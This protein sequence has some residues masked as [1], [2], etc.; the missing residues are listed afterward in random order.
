MQRWIAG[1][2]VL[3]I[4]LLCSGARRTAAQ[5]SNTLQIYWRHEAPARIIHTFESDIDQDGFGEIGLVTVDDTIELLRNDRTPLWSSAHQT[6][7]GVLAITARADS[8]VYATSQQLVQVDVNGEIDWSEGISDLPTVKDLY[9]VIDVFGRSSLLVLF[10]DGSMQLYNR[11]GSLRWHYEHPEDAISITDEIVLVGDVDADGLDDVLF[12]YPTTPNSSLIQ[13]IDSQDG[14]VKWDATI[15]GRV[16]AFSPVRFTNGTSAIAVGNDRGNIVMINGAEEGIW[17]P[18]SLEQP[19]T[20]LTMAEWPQADRI[21]VAATSDGQIVGLGAT[22]RRIFESRICE[23]NGLFVT[24]TQCDTPFTSRIQRLEVGTGDEAQGVALVALLEREGESSAEI[25]FFNRSL[26]LLQNY[27]ISPIKTQPLLV[28]T[29]RD[30]RNEFLLTAFGSV[31][32]ISPSTSRRSPVQVNATLPSPPSAL[33]VGDFNQDRIDEMIVGDVSGRLSK[34]GDALYGDWETLNAD[35]IEPE[36][37]GVAVAK[38]ALLKTPETGFSAES[39]HFLTVYNRLIEQG[40]GEPP[41]RNSTLALRR[42]LDGGLVWEEPISISGHTVTLLVDQAQPDLANVL[43]GLDNGVLAKFELVYQDDATFGARNSWVQ[44]DNNWTLSL[45]SEITYGALLERD[46]EMGSRFVITTRNTVQRYDAEGTRLYFI[47]INNAT[48]LCESPAEL[49]YLLDYGGDVSQPCLLNRR[50]GL[51]EQLLG[52]STRPTAHTSDTFTYQPVRL[53]SLQRTKWSESNLFGDEEIQ[54]GG[55]SFGE[56]SE[57]ISDVTTFY[58][59]DMTGNGRQDVAIGRSDGSLLLD[60]NGANDTTVQFGS[61]VLFL[62]ALHNID[63]ATLS[64]LTEN[65]LIH[66]L[67]FRSN[68]PPLLGT[69]Q[70]TLND[71]QVTLQLSLFDPEGD[72]VVVALE[73]YDPETAVWQRHEEQRSTGQIYRLQWQIDAPTSAENATY[74][75]KYRDSAGQEGTITPVIPLP[76]VVP[77][78]PQSSR[79]LFVAIAF[80]LVGGTLVLARQRQSPRRRA[81]RLVRLVE[82]TPTLILNELRHQYNLLKGDPSFF[83]NVSTSARQYQ[84][85]NLAALADGLYL[86]ADRP[87]AALAVINA[88]LAELSPEI[89]HYEQWT[90]MFGSTEAFL[91]V[92]TLTE[93]SLMRPRLEEMLK[94]N[95]QTGGEP[96]SFPQLLPIFDALQDADRVD[97]VEDRLTYLGDAEIMLRRLEQSVADEEHSLSKV[98]VQTIVT[99]WRGL[100]TAT[101]EALRGRARLDVQLKT[102]RIAPTEEAQLALEVQ[103]IGRAAAE[104]VTITLLAGEAMP[105]N[106]VTKTIPL[107]APERK[108]TV[109]FGINLPDT[110]AFRVAFQITYSDRQQDARTLDYANL[111]HVL[112]AVK[113]FRPI[114]NP[115]SPGTPLRRDSSLF[116]GR[117]DLFNFIAAEVERVT[118]QHVLILVG[119]RRTGKTSALLRLGQHLPKH[120]IPV[121]IDCQSLGVLPGMTAFFQDVAW[122]IADILFERDIDIEVPELEEKRVNPGKWFQHEFIPFVRDQ[123]DDD[124]KIVLVF[125]EFEALENL[126]NDDILP[127]TIFSYLRHLMQHGEGLSFIFV[128][129]HRLE[130]MTTNY[131]S[132]LFNIALY[133]EISYLDQEAARQLIS[134]PVAP[135]LTYDDLAIDKIIRLTAGHPYFLQLVCYSLVKRANEQRTGYIT[136]TD[137]NETVD[138]MLGLGEVHFAYIWQRSNSAERTVLITIAHLID[139]ELPFRVTDIVAELNEYKIALT[140]SDVTTALQS[141]VQRNVVQEVNQRGNTYYEM[142]LGLVGQWVERTKSLDKLFGRMLP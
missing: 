24:R 87:N 72:E 92:Q 129:T 117:N 32:L 6:G 81:L 45:P 127:R 41:I 136:I 90:T 30:G 43:V 57:T 111:V 53:A 83:V 39:D 103:N 37:Q 110:D 69:P 121:Y 44:T 2:T 55:L 75:L 71:D 124:A 88:T 141:L 89:S 86:V 11:T 19:I 112:A 17:E 13:L 10:N 22:G 56:E 130:E 102:Q 40:E 28:D 64:V 133:K 16:T 132:V 31:D 29:N 116:F 70:T 80:G 108:R 94:T 140:P 20:A 104:Q 27:P 79:L 139:R 50:L 34:Y 47:E 36:T 85:A 23:E 61:R 58:S 62:T 123:L 126:V 115:Y 125:D 122:Q 25:L 74:R 91:Q 93:L 113:D 100:V 76:I 99:R 21:L 1:V 134:E 73:Q 138:E 142:K 66:R 8:V 65:S 120:L 4:V 48:E 67:T 60:L 3:L 59:D 98:L 35:W 18:L 77:I 119:Q 128:G 84:N 82:R 101:I 135:N 96:G 12:G 105:L 14:S 137:V 51:W 52:S 97:T 54:G 114:R 68:Y 106:G 33:L 42:T 9:A 7:A 63:N 107:L 5:T 109:Q 38:L 78:T 118:Q 46:T 95:Q 49:L 26:D 15:D 131:W